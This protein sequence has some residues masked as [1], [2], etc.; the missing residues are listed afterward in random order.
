MPGHRQP[1]PGRPEPVSREV[2]R[3]LMRKCGTFQRRDPGPLPQQRVHD[4]R[5]RAA[6]AAFTVK[7]G[8]LQHRAAFVRE[9]VLVA[10][11]VRP[12]A[13]HGRHGRAALAACPG[14][15]CTAESGVHPGVSPAARVIPGDKGGWE[16]GAYCGLNFAS[17]RFGLPRL[18]ACGLRR[19]TWWK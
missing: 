13:V 3:T 18:P 14:L 7:A 17:G 19:P 9:S 10:R 2:R 6:T 11:S 1:I 15:M 16:G 5:V 12:S 4:A 8:A